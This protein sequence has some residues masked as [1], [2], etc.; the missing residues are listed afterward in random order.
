MEWDEILQSGGD[1]AARKRGKSPLQKKQE[2]GS[3]SKSQQ[4]AV[5]TDLCTHGIDWT[6]RHY[7]M[8]S[9]AVLRLAARF[10]KRGDRRA[11]EFLC[12]EKIDH[13][14]SV[15][16]QAHTLSLRKIAAQSEV[17]EGELRVVQ[18]MILR[19]EQHNE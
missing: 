7:S 5:V 1:I 3:L 2:K 12:P 19:R 8:S 17:S 6:C 4:E 14:E 10:V 11:E 9:Q 13:L 18:A 16:L 15:L